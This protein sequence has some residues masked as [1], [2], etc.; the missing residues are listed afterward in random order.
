M[1][2]TIFFKSRK[3][4][5]A[6]ATLILLLCGNL[7]FAQNTESTKAK[8]T[9]IAYDT[10]FSYYLENGTQWQLKNEDGLLIKT[11]VGSVENHIFSA[12]GNYVLHI[13]EIHTPDS[14]NHDHFPK[15]L[16]IEV[17]SN[18][19][20]FDF[21]SVKFSKNI[22]GGK[23][24]NGI[25]LTVNADFTSID[26]NSAEYT[27][28]FATVGVDTSIKGKL[29]EEKVMLQQGLNTLEFLL[30]GQASKDNY[31]MMDF[32]DINGNVQSYGLTQKIQ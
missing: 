11:G 28:G 6:Y 17:S 8:N 21:S 20:E 26:K 23:L 27:F 2:P 4:R 24:T 16:T 22:M 5:I 9:L 32:I 30:E 19:M 25:T 31:I 1:K 14:C 3:L 10:P 13:H 7:I 29:K 15:S 18:K 12:P